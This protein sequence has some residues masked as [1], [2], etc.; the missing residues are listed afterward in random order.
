MKKLMLMAYGI[1]FVLAPSI[2]SAQEIFGPV[3]VIG[4][5]SKDP[6]F[7]Q[8]Q[9]NSYQMQQKSYSDTLIINLQGSDKILFIG[10]KLEWMVRYPNADSLK[11]LF[12]NDFE[13]AVS[14]NS[15]TKEVQKVYYFVHGAGKRRLKA[16]TPEYTD[17]KVDVDY[18]IKR[19]KFDI[20]KYQYVIYDLSYG[21]ELHIY[22]NDPEQI[23]NI[24]TAVNLNDA[25]HFKEIDKK[26]IRTC[27][28]VEINANDNNY[29]II[30]KTSSWR[31]VFS[32]SP[33][34]GISILG[35]IVA[36]GF[37]MDFGII[38][39]DKYAVGKYKVEFGYNASSIV[40]MNSGKITGVSMVESYNLRTM[41]NLNTTSQ[42]CWYGSQAGFMK[43]NELSPFNNAIKYSLIFEKPRYT[44]SLD[45]ITDRNRNKIYGLTFNILF[46]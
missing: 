20:P 42:A 30:K 9:N 22:I 43:S 39:L 1:C 32:A 46:L 19:L 5:R 2:V 13:K 10:K 36:P 44:Y 29:R 31:H 33:N 23:R 28:K 24:L 17:N 6:S 26:T 11:M 21:Y 18:E 35:N 16:E 41:I 15:I 25:I 38:W 34:M 7:L 4:K 45:M 8:R 3:K 12:L 40:Y 27:Y 37:G 14:G